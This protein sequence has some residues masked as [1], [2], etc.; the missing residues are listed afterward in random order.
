MS[1]SRWETLS[2][3]S[4]QAVNLKHSHLQWKKSRLLRPRDNRA[5][6]WVAR[7]KTNSTS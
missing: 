3:F 2:H 6:Q 1:I 4:T 5:A 7:R